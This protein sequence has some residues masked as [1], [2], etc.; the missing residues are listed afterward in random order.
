MGVEYFKFGDFVRKKYVQIM[1]FGERSPDI[2]TNQV[3][4]VNF[5]LLI[6]MAI[7]LYSLQYCKLFNIFIKYAD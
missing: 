5:F 1:K 2:F 4:C 6:I 3:N 7:I